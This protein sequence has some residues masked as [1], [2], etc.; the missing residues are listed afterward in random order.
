[1]A[2]PVF[3]SLFLSATVPGFFKN[4]VE[5]FQSLSLIFFPTMA[6][7]LLSPCMTVL[8]IMYGRQKKK[9]DKGLDWSLAVWFRAG[10]IGKVV[11]RVESRCAFFFF[12]VSFISRCFGSISLGGFYIYIDI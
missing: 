12:G 6:V 8:G 1:M 3:F 2:C 4:R 7:V 11:V 9:K 5:G 10:G